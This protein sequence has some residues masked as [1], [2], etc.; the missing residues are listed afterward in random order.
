[1]RRQLFYDANTRQQLTPRETT[2]LSAAKNYKPVDDIANTLHIP[3]SIVLRH[4]SNIINKLNSSDQKLAHELVY[5]Y[6]LT[7]SD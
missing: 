6:K 1:M 7:T 3:Q 2:V 5:A 4:L